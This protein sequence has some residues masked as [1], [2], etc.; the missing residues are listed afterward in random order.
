MSVTGGDV[1]EITYNHPNLGDGSFFIKSGE[2][3]TFDPG[4][5]RTEDEQGA[6][7]GNGQMI[8]KINRN[9]WS[10]EGP[11]VWDMLEQNEIETLSAL[12]AN[13]LDA[14]FTISHINGTIWRGEGTVVGD[15]QG[16]GQDVT[17]PVKFAGGGVLT[18][19]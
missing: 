8:K 7:S 17:I 3:T 15:I 16:S 18:K 9:R 2:D 10:L 1:F 12:A 11:V 14:Q 13:P 5:L 4:G 6:I 19:L